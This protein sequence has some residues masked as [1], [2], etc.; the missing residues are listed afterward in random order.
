MLPLGKMWCHVSNARC[1]KG[2]AW[3]LQ[4][5]Q[6]VL[7]WC[8]CSCPI[9][10]LCEPVP[11]S[12]RHGEIKSDL[13]TGPAIWE[14]LTFFLREKM[15]VSRLPGSPIFSSV[16]EDKAV[17]CH[18][19]HETLIR[20]IT[21]LIR[22][23]ILCKQ[24][25]GTGFCLKQDC[26]AV[27]NTARPECLSAKFYIW[28]HLEVSIHNINIHLEIKSKVF[29]FAFFFLCGC[30][31]WGMKEQV[32]VFMVSV[33]SSFQFWKTFTKNKIKKSSWTI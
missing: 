3:C 21:V 5:K 14:L 8:P 12:V 13:H 10:A 24:N 17:S 33:V 28:K 32:C 20:G 30:F 4:D 11:F 29:L 9:T 26:L 7:L 16:M 22:L 18:Q 1:I 6:L 31:L 15:L 19:W 23:K 27:S 25:I 2:R